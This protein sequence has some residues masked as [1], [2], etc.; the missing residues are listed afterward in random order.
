MNATRSEDLVLQLI[1]LPTCSKSLF[2]ATMSLNPLE[3]LAYKQV[4]SKNNFTGKIEKISKRP[5]SAMSLNFLYTL[6]NLSICCHFLG[7]ALLKEHES[8]FG[9]VASAPYSLHKP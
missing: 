7:L 5:L 4:V 1:C 8:A 9:R 6:N 2:F 3:N